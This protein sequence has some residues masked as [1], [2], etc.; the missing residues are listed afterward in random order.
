MK[1]IIVAFLLYV[2]IFTN[3]AA[4]SDT[5]YLA[6]NARKYADSV[7]LRWNGQNYKSFAGINSGTVVIEKKNGLEA[8]WKKADELK[9]K[10]VES[11]PV[12][13]ANPNKQIILAAS[14]IQQI[15]SLLAAPDNSLENADA[16]QSDL[17]YL[18]MN[19][20]LSADINTVAADLCN[21][22][23]ADLK[24]GNKENLIYR[25]YIINSAFISDTLFFIMG[26]DDFKAEQTAQPNF[27]EKENQVEFF[28]KS[29]KKYSAYFIEKSE[30]GKNNFRQ[31]N[32]GP[33]VVPS[34]QGA[35]PLL[36]YK[37]SVTN[38]RIGYYRVYAIDMFGDRSLI[39]DTITAQGKDRTPP[40]VPSGFEVR[41]NTDNTLVLSW[42]KV[43]ET[44]GE[45]GIAIGMKHSNEG[46]YTPLNS[47]L[48]P[49][50]QQNYIVK[51]VAGITDYYFLIQVFDT[52]GNGSTAEAFYQLN[53]N[54][55][56]AKPLDLKAVVD[57]KGIVKL[58]WKLGSEKDLDGYLV[59]FSNS[60]KTE[61]SG[62]MNVP[63][64]DTVFYDTL[65]LKMLN[66]DVYYQ[67]RAADKRFNLSER[68]EIVKVL[69]PDTLPPVS[70]V[71]KSYLVTDS[72]IQFNWIPS[73]SIDVVT[74]RLHR[75]HVKTGKINITP[76]KVTDTLYRDRNLISEDKYEYFI[77]A[78]DDSK[79]IS[80]PSNAVSLATYKNYYRPAV[81]ILHVEYDSSKKNVI[82][83]WNYNMKDVKKIIIFK[84]PSI[85]RVS[86]MPDDIEVNTLSF[87]DYR[88]KKGPVFYAVKMY[89]KD[90]TETR[91][92]VP[93]GVVIP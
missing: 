44:N 32:R 47:A 14:G 93:V 40:P 37:D 51:P 25:I 73:S 9:P 59:Y 3:L 64:F 46:Q 65:S 48:L 36:F 13:K 1:R 92:S 19:V 35:N 77:T 7:V 61:F 43:S 12:S 63:Y 57:K 38:Y 53:D 74:H 82:F 54:T 79:N 39:S 67:I 52:V 90:G 29:D 91:L 71:I 22:R 41:E 30:N 55:P 88:I 62:I 28:W 33:L 56:P 27:L 78:E 87:T 49:L 66:R 81:S 58:T 15:N 31:L 34:D 42:N 5:I 4:Q 84:G 75:K 20:S 23:F 76:L 8:E 17:N 11:W 86:R 70:P 50:A 18:W 89:F 2:L 85:D 60:M 26:D 24:P 83:S 16:L 6:G 68:S 80:P 72:T 45:K 10:P 21:L 69:R